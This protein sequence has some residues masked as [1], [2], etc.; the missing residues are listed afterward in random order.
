MDEIN[1]KLTYADAILDDNERYKVIIDLRYQKIKVYESR[2][3]EAVQDR[4][5]SQ[6]DLKGVLDTINKKKLKEIN[7]IFDI[8]DSAPDGIPLTGKVKTIELN[9][10]KL[11]TEQWFG[12]KPAVKKTTIINPLDDEAELGLNDSDFRK[13]AVDDYEKTDDSASIDLKG[14]DLSTIRQKAKENLERTKKDFSTHQEDAG[15]DETEVIVSKDARSRV[16]GLIKASEAKKP[17]I[18]H[19]KLL[20]DY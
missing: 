18:D 10:I 16:T 12:I 9:R 8:I 13:K 3:Q 17:K 14:I 20:I 6:T 7:Q 5:I 1:L 4:S 19:K 11:E 15:E 2:I